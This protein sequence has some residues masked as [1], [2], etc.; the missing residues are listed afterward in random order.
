VRSAELINL[1]NVQLKISLDRRTKMNLDKAFDY[2]SKAIFY[3]KN[4]PKTSPKQVS[5]ICQ[6]LMETQIGLSMMASTSTRR[7]GHA[8]QAREYGEVALENVT[9]CRDECMVAQM[10]FLLACIT[11]WEMYL[12][13]EID[14]R[15]HQVI[16]TVQVLL[17]TRLNRLRGFKEL[18]IKFYE[19]QM[20]TY[21]GYLQGPGRV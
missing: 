2:F 10:D 17:E 21:L 3:L 6:K 1:G 18:K 13:S 7:K 19:E 11:A 20:K 5:R 4:D 16:E 12:Q 14:G 9:K 15:D 8:Q